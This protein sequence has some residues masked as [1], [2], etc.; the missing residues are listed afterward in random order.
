MQVTIQSCYIEDLVLHCLA[1]MKVE[2]DSDLYNEAYIK[3]IAKKK[4][5]LQLENTLEEKMQQLKAVYEEGFERLGLVNFIPFYVHTAKEL[6]AA[7]LQQPFFTAEDKEQ[8]LTPFLAILQ[9]EEAFYQGYWTEQMEQ[10]EKV[11]Q[12]ILSKAGEFF[13]HI[14]SLTDKI[15]FPVTISLQLS[16][17]RAGRAMDMEDSK[18]VA[19]RYPLHES[20]DI[21][22]LLQVMHELTHTFTD[23]LLHNEI[24]MGDGTHMYAEYLVFIADYILLETYCPKLL[25][26]YVQFLGISAF[27]LSDLLNLYPIEGKMLAK[28]KEMFQ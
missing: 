1:H 20:E 17:T 25:Q 26:D 3:T 10:A 15:T 6:E 12:R 5:A 23:E 13:T 11:Q 27:E 21:N 16:M 22:S 14:P 18:I 9:E 19:V 8:F 7:L 2:N 24:K 28:I 4:D